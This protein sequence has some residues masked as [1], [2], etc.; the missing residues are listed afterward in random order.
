MLA[1][2]LL[3]PQ[4]PSAYFM[5]DV[6]LMVDKL[7]DFKLFKPS[8]QREETR[9]SLAGVEGLKTKKLMGALRALWRSSKQ[10]G[11]DQKI[12]E[13]K[14]FLRPS[15]VPRRGVPSSD[16]EPAEDED[17][18]VE[19]EGEGDECEGGEGG[20]A[21]EGEHESADEGEHESADEGEHESADE[22]EYESAD[23]SE[24]AGEGGGAEAGDGSPLA[25]DGYESDDMRDEVLST[26]AKPCPP[27][28]D[29]EDQES[30]DTLTAKTVRL[31]GSSESEDEG[32]ESDDPDLQQD[33]QVSSGWLGKAYMAHNALENVAKNKEEKEEWLN[34]VVYGVKQDLDAQ[35]VA[36]LGHRISL[37]AWAGYAVW[38]HNAFEQYG[39]QVYGQLASLENFISWIH[40]EDEAGS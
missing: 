20:S 32:S 34:K 2:A 35:C 9:V 11:S 10:Q 29:N 8:K 27:S 22:G 38:C 17:G 1:R 36:E 19:N 16:D 15:P 39:H 40:R 25:E 7:L 23:E 14:S 28:S 31:G 26:D 24:R 33:S 12:T 21:D 3:D 13:L 18:E 4:V 6:F 37:E 30:H 5:T